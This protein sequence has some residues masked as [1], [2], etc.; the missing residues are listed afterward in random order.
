MSAARSVTATFGVAG[1]YDLT[2]TKAG[3]GTGT[4]TSSPTGINCGTDC[5]ESYSSRRRR[6]PHRDGR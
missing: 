3:A 6:H 1:T 5:S 2:V 4:V